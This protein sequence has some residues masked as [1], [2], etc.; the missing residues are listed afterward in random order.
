M[1]KKA[2]P[3]ALKSI[4]LHTTNQCQTYKQRI[5]KETRAQDDYTT[6]QFDKYQENLANKK[7]YF[8]IYT[9]PDKTKKEYEKTMQKTNVI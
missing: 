2:A 9:S 8:D 7:S 4:E 1:A 3:S 5:E 6:Q